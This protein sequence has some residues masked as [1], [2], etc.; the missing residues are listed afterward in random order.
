MRRGRRGVSLEEGQV[1]QPAPVGAG[2][3][4]DPAGYGPA[5]RWFVVAVFAATLLWAVSAARVGWHHTLSDWHGFRQTQTALTSYYLLKGG[6]FFR[7]ET[8]VVGYPWSIPFEF[9]LYQWVVAF[10]ARNLHTPLDQTGRFVSEVFFYLSLLAMWGV[11][12]ELGVRRTY[13]LVFLTLTLAS[14]EY[15]FYSR[16]FMIESTALS[17]CVAYLYFILRYVRTRR[18]SDAAL[19]GLCGTLGALVKVTTFPSFALVA[20]L[21][22]LFTLNRERRLFKPSKL[23]SSHAAPLLTFFLLPLLVTKAWVQYTDQVKMLNTVG[24]QLTSSAL[25]LWNFG[26]LRHRF[27]AATWRTFFLRIVPDIVGG[28]V[29]GLLPLVG[30]CFARY[31]LAA[32]AVSVCGFLACFLVFIQLHVIHGYYAYANG[33]FLIAAVSWCI[34]ALLEARGWRAVLGAA[35]L[36]IGAANSVAGYYGRG[37]RLQFYGDQKTPFSK[38]QGANS[39]QFAGVSDAAMRLT[40]PDDVLLG[41]GLE[42]SSELPY[43]SQRRAV[44]WPSFIGE[45]NFD[46]PDLRET[47]GKL[48]GNHIG[49][50]VVCNASR[51]NSQLIL[52]ATAEF[53]LAREPAYADEMCAVYPSLDNLT[54]GSRRP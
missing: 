4:D 41:F 54:D 6:P 23:L 30:L 34:V 28:N 37:Y 45:E 46:N 20:G 26:T 27:L 1:N 44:M 10:L 32:F 2:P 22:Y 13:R 7:Y 17:F 39:L 33:V 51:N 15:V 38:L 42:W 50:L 21:Y 49:A 12:S 52:R 25:T 36:L 18:A 53:G 24:T 19:G 11:L 8:P 29:V 40:R 48:G 31:R 3:A 35:L 9:P 43:Y 47:L 14:P 16:T 5:L